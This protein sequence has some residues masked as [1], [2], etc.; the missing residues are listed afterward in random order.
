MNNALFYRLTQRLQV[1]KGRITCRLIILSLRKE[2]EQL[3][4]KKSAIFII[5]LYKGMYVR[6]EVIHLLSIKNFNLLF[7]NELHTNTIK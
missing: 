4:G 7:T 3:I 1:K 5:L 6:D 2:L